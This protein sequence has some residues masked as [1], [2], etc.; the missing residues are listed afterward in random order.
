MTLFSSAKLKL[1]YT[2]AVVSGSIAGVSAFPEPAHAVV[3]QCPSGWGLQS[4]ADLRGYQMCKAG[5][6]FTYSGWVQIIDLK[7]GGRVVLRSE[8]VAG[9]TLQTARFV[10]RNADEWWNWTLNYTTSPSGGQLQ[11]VVNASF[12]TDVSQTTSPLSWAQKKDGVVESTGTQPDN[13]SKRMLG[14]Y[15][16]G[17]KAL[18]SDFT[19]LGNATT[20]I[21]NSMS[22]VSSGLVSCAPT[23]CFSATDVNR[24]TFV[25]GRDT[26]GNGDID[27]LYIFT[28]TSNL[29]LAQTVSILRDQFST[30]ANIQMDGGGSTQMWGNW[31]NFGSKGCWIPLPAYGCRKVPNVLAIYA[32]P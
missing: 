27:R 23:A 1:L 8:K 21:T 9:G 11:S 6:G 7:A 15:S 31:D 4:N 14:F 3:E 13:Q 30:S 22:S 24:R 12:F 18:I 5:S 29:T 10:R 26:D 2:A 19:Y 16:G 32:A 20:N 17:A 25:G 28:T